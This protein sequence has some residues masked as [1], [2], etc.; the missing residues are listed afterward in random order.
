MRALTTTF[1]DHVNPGSLLLGSANRRDR[2]TVYDSN[3]IVSLRLIRS[4]EREQQQRRLRNGLG[5]ARTQQTPQAVQLE[6]RKALQDSRLVRQL[7]GQG[8]LGRMFPEHFGH[9]SEHGGIVGRPQHSGHEFN[10]NEHVLLV[11]DRVR[12]HPEFI[13]LSTLDRENLLLAAMLHDIAKKASI[14]DPGHEKRGA[15]LSR[16]LLSELCFAQ[17]R[18]QTVAAIISR[19]TEVSYLPSNLVSTKLSNQSALEDIANHYRTSIALTQLRIL[20][21]SDIKS[22]SSDSAYWTPEVESELNLIESIIA[23]KLSHASS[24]C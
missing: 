16:V 14:V 9:Y 2:L 13:E 1:A 7:W 8:S 12:N 5:R 10:L 24:P 17:R 21:E 11:M 23:N 3:S 15:T 22:I 19:H 20:N 6:L 4:V 18:I